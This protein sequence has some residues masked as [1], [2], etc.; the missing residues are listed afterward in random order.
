MNSQ[1]ADRTWQSSRKNDVD[2]YYLGVWH[3]CVRKCAYV[4]VCVDVSV[5]MFL[6][7][8]VVRKLSV[9]KRN[10]A[11]EFNDNAVP[12]ILQA[13][14][15]SLSIQL[16]VDPNTHASSLS[17]PWRARPQGGTQA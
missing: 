16:N 10:C 15:L 8:K 17:P 1:L 9:V 5:C 2:K 11:K 12:R 6:G 3:G 14:S 4:H 13:H 7:M